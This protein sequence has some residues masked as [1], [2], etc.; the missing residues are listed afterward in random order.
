MRPFHG[1]GGWTVCLSR[2]SWLNDRMEKPPVFTLVEES[3]ESGTNTTAKCIALPSHKKMTHQFAH[4]IHPLEST[5]L[6]SSYTAAHQGRWI[7]LRGEI[8]PF[9]PPF[10]TSTVQLRLFTCTKLMKLKK[11]KSLQ[12]CALIW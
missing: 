10:N 6:L 11:A 3:A 7:L 9:M 2:C 12:S 5:S 4:F 8:R 1:T